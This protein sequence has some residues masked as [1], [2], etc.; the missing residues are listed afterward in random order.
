[1]Q[2]LIILK[3]ITK[4]LSSFIPE[5]NNWSTICKVLFHHVMEVK[6]GNRK[7][8]SISFRNYRVLLLN[9]G[10]TGW[11]WRNEQYFFLSNF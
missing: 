6:Y 9:W 5:V 4:S 10:K 2:K 11:Q 3:L 7:Q 8:I 1:M